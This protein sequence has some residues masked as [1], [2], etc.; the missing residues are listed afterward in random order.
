MYVFLPPLRIQVDVTVSISRLVKENSGVHIYIKIKST[1]VY[2]LSH[3][4][5]IRSDG[6]NFDIGRSFFIM[7]SY[8]DQY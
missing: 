7:Y 3:S 4:I 6:I 1:K 5:I 8:I 2:I